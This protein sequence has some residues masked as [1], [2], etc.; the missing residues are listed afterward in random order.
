MISTGLGQGESLAARQGI[1]TIVT[2]SCVGTSFEWYDFFV[3]GSLAS[4]I[5]R[6]FF[7]GVPEAAGFILALGAFGAGFAFRPLGS[8]VFGWLG[9]RL[10]RK[11]AFIVTV[12]LMGG[13]TVGI[14]LLPTYAQAGLLSPSLLIFLRIV[15]GFALGG[16]YGGAAVYVAEHSPAARRGY[17]TSWIQIAAS[18][19]LIG[20]LVVVLLARQATGESAFA[21]WGWRLPFVASAVLVLMSLYMRARLEESPAYKAMRAE[22]GQSKA[23]LAEAFFTWRRLKVVL[24]ALFG[25]TIAQGAVWYSAFFYSQF[26]IQKVLKLDEA[27]VNLLMIA[28]AVVSAPLYVLF[29]ALSDRV[30]RKPVMVAGMALMTLAYFPG[31]HLLTQAANPALAAAAA[32]TPVTVVADPN[33]CSS[34]FDLVGKAVF[35]SSCDIAKST[36]ANAGVSYAN[37]KAAPGSLA[38][39]RVGPASVTSRSAV[40]LSPADQKVVKAEVAKSISSALSQ[41]GYPASADPKQVNWPLLIGVMLVFAVAA[42]ALY[43]PQAAALVELFPTRIRYTAMSFPYNIGVGWIGGF[44]PAAAFAIVAVDGNMYAGLWYPLGF[45]LLSV[46]T[47]LL[48]LRE[49]RGTDLHGDV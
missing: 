10:G 7:S 37:A 21:A 28:V 12:A 29:G 40:G 20:A 26:F 45:T 32:R 15:Q 31:F 17:Y 11:V 25:V 9:D 13:A 23:P 47:A 1:R 30:G 41:A 4:L 14:G 5:S 22:G 43:G 2:A 38:M 46:C 36:L 42:T 48:C 35:L 39:V 33:D 16:Q 19:G 8:L 18:L 44:L 6:N 34:Q 24:I 27:S 49:T 3:F